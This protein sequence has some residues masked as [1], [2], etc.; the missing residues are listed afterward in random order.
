MQ[1]QPKPKR[2]NLMNHHAP[3]DARAVSPINV[4]QTD[5]NLS[6]LAGAVMVVFGLSRG[7]R[8]AW[9]A[10]MGGVLIYRGALGQDA[11]YKKLG[12]S[13]AV[14]TN[15]GN[16]AVPHQQ[17]IHV[18]KAV[19]INRPAEALYTY[20]RNFEN[21]PRVMSHLE[22]VTVQD[23]VHS[24]WVAKAPAGMT[25]AWDA[26]IINEVPN[27]VIG[28][29]SLA[30]ADIANAG[31]V[32]FSPAPG[33]RGTEV[34]VTL[35]YVP[36]AGALGAAIA[37]LLGEEPSVQVE[38]DLRRFKQMMEIGHAV[39]TDDQPHGDRSVLSG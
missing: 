17:G 15:K 29:R 33:N 25:V 12:Y 31:S 22:S 9:L 11:L 30:N 35:E 3:D 19:T 2:M 26:E 38:N 27:E 5:R 36:P 18:E 28:W 24:H 8:G 7:A 14:A 16:V 10:L 32:R 6:L 37:R 13:S 20:W 21:L 1:Y 34:R 4:G 23:S 39:S